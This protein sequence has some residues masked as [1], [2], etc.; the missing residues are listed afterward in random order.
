MTNACSTCRIE[1]DA[2]ASD[3]LLSCVTCEK[4]FHG[5]CVSVDSVVVEAILSSP[6]IF[7]RCDVCV[8]TAAKSKI[9]RSLEL[10]FGK[11]EALSTDMD[12]LKGK[13]APLKSFASAL[14]DS[15]SGRG[16]KRPQGFGSPGS[17]FN[18]RKRTETKV[19]TPALIMGVGASNA[20]IKT[21]EPLK[22][23]YVSN[24]DPQTSEDAVVKLISTALESAPTEFS[25]VKLLPK[26]VMAP[27][28]ISFKIGM[29][30]DLFLKSMA[31]ELWP[32]GIAF[33]EFIDRPRNFLR[34]NA[35]RIPE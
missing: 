27:T 33:R 16:E 18:K 21:I 32:S 12:A 1:C 7:W 11:L 6:N 4:Q 10:I 13:S 15:E 14:R 19:N 9:D 26:N 35:T 3:E 2:D 31:P 29:K 22:W 24:L 25:C 30:E 8:D 17:P 23:L 20:E 28:F 5:H 34:R